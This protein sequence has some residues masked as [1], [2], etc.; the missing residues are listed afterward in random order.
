MKKILLSI[1]SSIPFFVFSTVGSTSATIILFE[2]FDDSSAL[3][4]DGAIPRYWDIA[5][6][7]GTTLYS[8]QFQQG[9]SSQ[10]GNIFY[11]VYAKDSSGV[12]AT[13]TILL[14]DLSLYDNL[15]LT[16]SLA[17]PGRIWEPTHR[18]SLHIIGSTTTEPPSISCATGG[19]CLPTMDT[20]DSF[21]PISYPDYLRSRVF[22]IPLGLEFQD[23]NYNI[24]STLKSLT[25][26]FASTD[27]PEYIGIDSVII[28]GDSI[29]EPVPEPGT[30]LLL[31]TGLLGVVGAAKRRKK[32]Q[33]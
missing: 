25:F 20:I 17:S 21:L 10:D 33:I 29:P 11:G 9:S 8:S 14:P 23:F 24:D 27:Y 16:V 28:T 32:N 3:I 13:M 22:S 7:G 12:S 26:A 2:N 19:G 5:P 6:L 30:I 18:D 31:G 1:L 15:E 4:L